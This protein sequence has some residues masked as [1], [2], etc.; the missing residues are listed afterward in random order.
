M[1]RVPSIALVFLCVALAAW[2]L[3]AYYTLHLNPE[4]A[5]FRQGAEVKSRWCAD[6]EVRYPHKIIVFGGSSCTTTIRAERLTHRHE[7]PTANM[8]LGAGMG[9]PVLTAYA[10]HYAR[11]G[12]VLVMAME[13]ALLEGDLAAPQLGVQFSL[14]RDH[15]EWFRGFPAPEGWHAWLELKPGGYHFFTLLGKIAGGRKL[16]RYSPEEFH[17]DGWQAVEA[18]RSMPPNLPSPPK[19]GDAGRRLL[20]SFAALCHKREMPCAF[21]LP[22]HYAPPDHADAARRANRNFLAEVSEILPVLEDGTTGIW[23][24]AGDFADTPF[25]LVPAAANLRTDRLAE[26]IR[27]WLETVS[28]AFFPTVPSPQAQ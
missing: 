10:L 22:W 5:F 2:A 16:Y 27:P 13:P 26:A 17:R 15:P 28:P 25:H 9:A 4:L 23:T 12:D 7:L 3:G 18:R 11:P 14:M 6:L 20:E 19:L 24:E 1:K 8:G 21:V